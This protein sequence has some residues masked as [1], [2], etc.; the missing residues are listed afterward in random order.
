M[1]HSAQAQKAYRMIQT[2][3]D[4]GGRGSTKKDTL[5]GIGG[6]RRWRARKRAYPWPILRKSGTLRNRIIREIKP[7]SFTLWS[8]LPYS[9]AHQLGYRPGKLPARPFLVLT[10]TQIR[11]LSKNYKKM[12]ADQLKF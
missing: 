6:S 1:D 8:K 3:F 12:I 4:V 10:R 7:K 5:D 9:R 11:Q 2:N